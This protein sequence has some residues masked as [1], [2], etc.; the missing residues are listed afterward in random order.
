MKP[1]FIPGE[2]VAQPRHKFRII[3]KGA[4]AIP[5]PYIPKSHPVHAWKE[6]VQVLFKSE[7]RT[8]KF[9]Q[10]PLSLSLGFVLGRAASRTKKR[11]DNPREWHDRRPDT[12][13]LAKSVMDA[14]SGVAWHDDAQVCQ[15]S[16]GKVMA[17]AA[18]PLGVWIELRP[19]DVSPATG[20]AFTP[21][22]VTPSLFG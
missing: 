12:D 14:L 9:E 15:L 7:S 1:I 21:R 2:P 4:A 18:E 16:I 6:S 8:P 3:G 17:S 19:V 22:L 13:N 5:V 20:S 10:G 11:G